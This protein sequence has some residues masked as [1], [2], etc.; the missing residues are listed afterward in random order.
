MKFRSLG[1]LVPM[2]LACV[3]AGAEEIPP[4]AVSATEGASAAD[5][6]DEEK[7]ARELA[8]QAAA[9]QAEF[10][11]EKSRLQSTYSAEAQA[12]AAYE[13][14]LRRQFTGDDSGTSDGESSGQGYT[15]PPVASFGSEDN[16]QERGVPVCPGD[17]R[18]P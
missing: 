15:T 13:A 16:G 17:P 7:R 10:E 3:P 18:C 14:E 5:I 9:A 12:R 6:S 4:A 2:L 11:S 8:A 1:L